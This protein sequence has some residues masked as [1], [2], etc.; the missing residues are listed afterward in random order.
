MT[1]ARPSRAASSSPRARAVRPP[2]GETRAARQ[3]A[4][5]VARG[6]RCAVE[7]A[8]AVCG[9]VSSC[10]VLANPRG[11]RSTTDRR[12]GDVQHA[13][14]IKRGVARCREA[15][16]PLARVRAWCGPA[17][18]RTAKAAFL[19]GGEVGRC[20]FVKWRCGWSPPKA[21]GNL[22]TPGSRPWFRLNFIS[23]FPNLCNNQTG[24][25]TTTR[26]QPR[27]G[28][29]W[30]CCRARHDAR[31]VCAHMAACLAS[32]LAGCMAGDGGDAGACAPRAATRA[33]AAHADRRATE[34]STWTTAAQCAP[35]TVGLRASPNNTTLRSLARARQTFSTVC[36]R[37]CAHS[38]VIS[39]KA[40]SR[41]CRSRPNPR[42]ATRP[43][44]ETQ[45]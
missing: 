31:G 45:H 15:L 36:T 4:D 26:R 32:L 9:C 44:P 5:G 23:R 43:E 18:V 37:R 12:R 17:H 20:A 6:R 30:G 40:A 27:L 16:R 38:A 21:V 24:L 1:S 29:V 11:S 2:F 39:S 28:L 25:L 22:D 10:V 7:S 8:R 33:I 35:L 14:A 42:S 41:A 34:R 19:W 3:S 13:S